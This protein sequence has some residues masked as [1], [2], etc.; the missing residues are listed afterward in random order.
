MAKEFEAATDLRAAFDLSFI[1]MLDSPAGR[2]KAGTRDVVKH[3]AALLGLS[4]REARER[5]TAVRGHRDK[6]GDNSDLPP[7]EPGNVDADDGRTDEE[8]ARA[9]AE[10]ERARRE[11]EARRRRNEE[12]RRRQAKERGVKRAKLKALN[13]E[14][15]ELRQGGK[16]T[17]EQIK[18]KITRRWGKWDAD[19]V[20]RETRALVEQSNRACPKDRF[21]DLRKRR[22]TISENPDADGCYTFNGVMTADMRA[23]MAALVENAA[24]K[25]YGEPRPPTA[26]RTTVPSSSGAMTSC[27]SCSK[28]APKRARLEPTVVAWPPSWPCSTRAMAVAGAGRMVRAAPASAVWWPPPTSAST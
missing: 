2:E 7:D 8:R 19:R 15:G 17:A 3:L 13:D 5:I 22:L 18:E 6:P 20:R 21:A 1:S 28:P 26:R 24:I 14:L 11:E 12:E 9:A 10:A 25:G 27:I 23:L 16:W 4:L